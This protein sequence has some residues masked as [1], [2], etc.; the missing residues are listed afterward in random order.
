MTD[1]QY[2]NLQV[3]AYRAGFEPHPTW[4]DKV[5]D[6]RR[7]CGGARWTLVREDALPDLRDPATLGCLHAY[8]EDTLRMSLLGIA[9][10]DAEAIIA[11]LEKHRKE[12]P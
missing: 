12:K 3:R 1:E 9:W 5:G 2:R 11:E 4:W 6:L 8:A 7:D 10:C